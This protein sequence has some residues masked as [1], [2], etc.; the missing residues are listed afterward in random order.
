LPE[1]QKWAY[2]FREDLPP[3]VSGPSARR[4]PSHFDDFGWLVER[5]PVTTDQLAEVAEVYAGLEGKDSL[6]LSAK[7]LSAAML[8]EE[9]DDAILD[10]LIGLEAMLSDKEKGELTFKLAVRTAAVLAGLRDYDPS[11]VFGHVK[12]L[13]NYRSAVAH[14]DAKRAAKLRTLEVAG[15]QVSSITLAT[16]FLRDVARQL[17]KHP[18]LA[19]ASDIDSKLIL[20]SLAEAAG[21]KADLGRS[22]S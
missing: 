9:E 20:R 7:R 2:R 11:V 4:Y 14:G 3:V 19:A 15:E 17:I 6:G 16:S 21:V 18:D 13:Y 10:L 8:R 5:E 22:V 1:G 12:Q